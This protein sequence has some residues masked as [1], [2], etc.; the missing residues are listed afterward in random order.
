MSETPAES[1]S[2]IHSGPNVFETA[3]SVISFESLPIRVQ[4]SLIC[5]RIVFTFSATMQILRCKYSSFDRNIK[6]IFGIENQKMN[7]KK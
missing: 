5:R 6:M 3:I 4:I 7:V 1:A 2:R